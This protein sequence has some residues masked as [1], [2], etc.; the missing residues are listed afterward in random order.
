MCR[1]RKTT[2]RSRPKTYREQKFDNIYQKSCEHCSA[3]K[4][5]TDNISTSIG[6]ACMKKLDGYFV[7]P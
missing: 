7:R 2:V 3:I 4:N 6:M 5:I 1:L